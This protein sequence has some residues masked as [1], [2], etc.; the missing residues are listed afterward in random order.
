M[1]QITRRA[2]IQGTIACAGVA[3]ASCGGAAPAPSTASPAT[4]AAS[5]PPSTAQI[6]A[7]VKAAWVAVTA[8]QMIFPLAKEAGYF[9]KYGINMDLSYINGSGTAVASLLSGETGAATAAGSAV[10]NAQ[11]A[12][13]DL[14]MVAGFLNQAVFRI[15]AM[16]AIK[17]IDDLRGDAIAVTKAGNA[18]YFAWRIVMRRQG[19]KESDL[20]FINGE[21]VAG[22]VALLQRGDAQAIAVSPPNDVLAERVGAHLVLDTTT[23]NEPEQNVGLI[24]SRRYLVQHR[25]LAIGMVKAS[26]EAMARWQQDPPFVKGVIRKYLKETDE[27]FVDTGYAAYASIWPRAPYPSRD[28]LQHVVEEVSTQNPKA[29]NLHADQLMDISIVK[30]LEDSGFIN[31]VYR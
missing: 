21:S 6:P 20:H 14:V 28:G 27:R 9:D 8:N 11:A 17:A 5:A 15:M 19:W 2:F 7:A 22:Q 12:G 18:D 3:L 24:M 1:K 23:L 10:I 30:E 31:E 29:K 13:S 26:I 4:S 16:P 25:P